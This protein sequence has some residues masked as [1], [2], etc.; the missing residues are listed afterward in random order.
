M[1]FSK[2]A[3]AVGNQISADIVQLETNFD[4][5]LLGDGT[6][7]QVIRSAYFK[8]EDGTTADTIKCTMTDNWNGDAIAAVDNIALTA[9]SGD[10]TYSANGTVDIA[11]SGLSGNCVAVLGHEICYNDSG[12]VVNI[13][14]YHSSN[15]IVLSFTN[16][17][18]GSAVVLYNILNTSKYITVKIL[19]LTDA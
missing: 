10:F 5:M 15:D 11:A 7:G 2:T 13:L 3:P 4:Y 8:V 12:T 6:D 9:T 19:Y 1:A 16:A 17:S 18:S 14:A